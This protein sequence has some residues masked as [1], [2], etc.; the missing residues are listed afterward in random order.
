MKKLIFTLIMLLA[1]NLSTAFADVIDY[2]PEGQ[3][4]GMRYLPEDDFSFMPI[5]WAKIIVVV[6]LLVTLV[7]IMIKRAKK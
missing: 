6:I 4:H 2:I 7:V 3:S 5:I 1:L